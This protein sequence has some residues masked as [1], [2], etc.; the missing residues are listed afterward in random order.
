[1]LQQIGTIEATACVYEYNDPSP[2]NQSEASLSLSSA[3]TN[4][5]NN[6]NYYCNSDNNDN[7]ENFDNHTMGTKKDSVELILRLSPLTGR[8]RAAGSRS[9]GSL[10][11]ERWAI[12]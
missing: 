1:M 9:I 6:N 12:R 5:N 11:N 2:P 3:D 10:I 7:N 8:V 4:Y